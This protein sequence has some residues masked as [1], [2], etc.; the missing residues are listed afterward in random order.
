[1]KFT[2]IPPEFRPEELA[3]VNQ[4]LK[5]L[6]DLQKEAGQQAIQYL[7]LTNSGG[8]IAVLGFIGASNAVRALTLPRV[9]LAFFACGVFLSGVL[10]ALRVHEF[11]WLLRCYRKELKEYLKT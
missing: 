5:Q 9:S 2:D 3:L 8:A 7:L 10:L 1:M 4:R 11:E 6:L